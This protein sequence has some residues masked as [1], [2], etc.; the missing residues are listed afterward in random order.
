M[1]KVRHFHTVSTVTTA[2]KSIGVYHTRGHESIQT[3]SRHT[4][5]D[6]AFIVMALG[7]IKT[8]FP[9]LINAAPSFSRLVL[10][11]CFIEGAAWL[12][13][14]RLSLHSAGNEVLCIGHSLST[15]QS[16][17]APAGYFFMAVLASLDTGC[18]RKAPQRVPLLA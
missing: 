13:R 5:I 6:P 3:L 8:V 11:S 4:L 7:G 18:L 9:Y 12:G 1:V 10:E 15:P 2:T 16:E 14:M 17:S